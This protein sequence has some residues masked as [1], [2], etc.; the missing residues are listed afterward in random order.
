MTIRY[1]AQTDLAACM[2]LDGHIPEG[3]YASK[4]AAKQVYILSE[5]GEA[6]A[7][8]RYG[9][10]WDSIPFC[11]LLFVAE[12]ARRRGYGRAL[13]IRWEA[14][15]KSRGYDLV[16]TSTQA[17]EE[18]QHFW[19]K[20]GYRDCGGFVLPFPGYEQPLELILAKPL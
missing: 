10:F 12:R 15:M 20:L 6:R 18:G 13:A 14:D 17:D 3:E 4:L 1:A 5:A 16:M 9:L 2:A 19:R 11:S 7:L 8:L